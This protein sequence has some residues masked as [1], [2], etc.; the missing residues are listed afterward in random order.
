MVGVS[1][2]T[3]DE[4]VADPRDNDNDA[5][6]ERALERIAL[7]IEWAAAGGHTS[8]AMRDRMRMGVQLIRDMRPSVVRAK[9]CKS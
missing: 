9:E 3:D 6:R 4:I 7:D 2:L 5:I 8:R 1:D